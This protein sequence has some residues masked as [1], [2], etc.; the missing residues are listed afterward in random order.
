ML[1]LLLR[2]VV[3]ARSEEPEI[4]DQKQPIA[5][6]ITGNWAIGGDSGQKL[7][8]AFT[9]GRSGNLTAVGLPVAGRGQL[10]VQ[11]QA[12]GAGRPNGDVLAER[13]VEGSSLP[14]FVMDPTGFR[15]IQL[16]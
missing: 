11:I 15:R 13:V 12:V 9:V 5:D 3:A 16:E 8:Q 14:D 4:L 7:A 6:V 10:I 1:A 2:A